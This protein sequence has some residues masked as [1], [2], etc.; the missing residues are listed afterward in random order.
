MENI[1]TA[2]PELDMLPRADT[3]MRLP[4]K[5]TAGRIEAAH[6]G[7]LKELVRKKKFKPLLRGGKYAVENSCFY[8]EKSAEKS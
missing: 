6:A 2:L 5:R 1:S 8:A 4:E 3:L 7:L